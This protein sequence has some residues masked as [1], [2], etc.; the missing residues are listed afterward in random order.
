MSE[1]VNESLRER[2]RALLNMT[3]ERGCT[4]AEAIVAAKMASALL[5]KYNLDAHEL[6]ENQVRF[7]DMIRESRDF[8]PGK[9][10]WR[11]Q[12]H[13]ADAIASTTQCKVIATIPRRQTRRWDATD[14]DITFV[15]TEMNA[16]I[17]AQMFEYLVNVG[18]FLL[19]QEMINMKQKNEQTGHDFSRS[20]KVGFAFRVAQRIREEFKREAVEQHAGAY[21][22]SMKEL[23]Q[24]Y[25]DMMYP[26]TNHSNRSQKATNN[27][28]FKRGVAAGDSISLRER[29][30]LGDGK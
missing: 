22:A 1:A 13:L 7:E 20:Y 16:T 24:E 14:G 8:K 28:G 3:T 30:R 18:L 4:E 6:D 19:T 25:Y 26:H 21:L 11:W 12:Y 29:Q 27:E 5:L 15:G 9:G 23:V 2:I 17:A 10:A